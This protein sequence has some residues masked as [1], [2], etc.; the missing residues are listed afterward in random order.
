MEFQLEESMSLLSY[1]RTRLPM[2]PYFMNKRNVYLLKQLEFVLPIYKEDISVGNNFFIFSVTVPLSILPT[3]T[4]LKCYVTHLWCIVLSWKDS[5]LMN[6]IVSDYSGWYQE[7]LI[8]VKNATC[9]TTLSI[10]SVSRAEK[11]SLSLK[12]LFSQWTDSKMIF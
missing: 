6:S 9:L 7:L 11:T 12:E 1:L 10:Q 5:S 8:S 4:V 3:R 2:L